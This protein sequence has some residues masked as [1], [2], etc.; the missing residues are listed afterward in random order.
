MRQ[1][2]AL[3]AKSFAGFGVFFLLFEEELA[4]CDPLFGCNNL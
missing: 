1:L 4:S 2:A 3:G